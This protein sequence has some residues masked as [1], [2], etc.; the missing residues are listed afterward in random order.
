[1]TLVEAAHP[2]G[3][4]PWAAAVAARKGTHRV[5]VCIPAR[6]EEATVERVVRVVVGLRAAG[7]VDEILVVDDASC[8]D[9]ARVAQRAGAAVVRSDGCHGK[10][11]ALRRA[12][13]ETT[14]DLLV[15]LDADVANFDQAYVL[16]LVLPLFEDPSVQL[17]K[18]AYDRPLLGE[19]SEGGRV[20]EILARPLLRR[21]FPELADVA[22]PLAGECAIRRSVLEWVVL[23]DGY[24]IEIGLLIDVCRAYGRGAVVDADLGERVHRNRP[25][26][27][28]RPHADDV[29]AAVLA[30]VGVSPEEGGR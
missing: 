24:G 29:L 21:F 27:Q 25:L 3:A 8:D 23:D 10:G 14:G 20:T 12:V 28:L 1:M 17:V 4:S 2:A 19:P 7:V 9:T 30:R 13:R 6:D 18:A 5:S 15:F 16:R 11:Q 26:A 22:Q